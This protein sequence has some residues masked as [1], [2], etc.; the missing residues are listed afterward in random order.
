VNRYDIKGKNVFST[1]EKYYV[2][3]MGLLQLKRSYVDENLSARLENIVANELIARNYTINIGIMPNAEI[4]FVAKKNNKT[5]Y[6]QVCYKID[7]DKTLQRELKAF[8]GIPEK[9]LLIT[10]DTY[11]YSQNG[12]ECV[13][14]LE[15]LTSGNP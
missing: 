15:W 9:K 8:K 6:I 12:V 10:A 13:N 7:S 3:D 2:A 11:N 14:A 1:L 4:D 5:E